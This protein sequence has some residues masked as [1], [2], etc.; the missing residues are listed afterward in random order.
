MDF[1]SSCPICV[2]TKGIASREPWKEKKKKLKTWV[3]EWN[4]PGATKNP[5][6][7]PLACQKCWTQRSIVVWELCHPVLLD[8]EVASEEQ[9][10]LSFCRDQ[11]KMLAAKDE[12][13]TQFLHRTKYFSLSVPI[14]HHQHTQRAMGCQCCRMIKRWELHYEVIASSCSLVFCDRKATNYPYFI[15]P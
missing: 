4:L 8:R 15:S 13:C 6:L 2:A 9:T 3:M 10:N 5:H 12:T 11:G 14:Q 7:K 1:L